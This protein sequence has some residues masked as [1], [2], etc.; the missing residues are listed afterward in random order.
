MP[1]IIT[2][3]VGEQI[4]LRRGAMGL[5]QA[6]LGDRLGVSGTYIGY[7]EGAKR[8]PSPEII[9]ALNAALGVHLGEPALQLATGILL[10][11]CDLTAPEQ[12]TLIERLLGRCR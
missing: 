3:P 11:R 7:L 4:R 10:D 1:E 6:Q 9:T 12:R 5:S 2:I 8:D